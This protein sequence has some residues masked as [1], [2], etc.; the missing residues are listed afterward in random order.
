MWLKTVTLRGRSYSVSLPAF[1]ITWT[2]CEE[3]NLS[4]EPSSSPNG[5]RISSDLD[6]S[7]TKR[8]LLSKSKSNGSGV[9]KAGSLS[10]T[11]TNKSRFFYIINDKL[12]ASLAKHKLFVIF[13]AYTVRC[14]IQKNEH[15]FWKCW[16]LIKMR[17]AFHEI[18]YPRRMSL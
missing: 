18:M 4:G 10:G 14:A 3:T 1:C 15:I 6:S 13:K 5:K 11:Q 9:K 17:L 12:R 2:T 16:K 8:D 7:R